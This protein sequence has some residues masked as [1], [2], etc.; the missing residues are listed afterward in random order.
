MIT[1]ERLK[2]LVKYDPTTGVFTATVRRGGYP[3]GT[4]LGSKGAKGYVYTVLD[5]VQYKTQYL[6]WVYM[7]GTSVPEGL[8]H[9]NGIRHDNRWENIAI[10]LEGS[11][12]T[13]RPF[14]ELV[15]GCYG[16]RWQRETRD[17]Y[18]YVGFGEGE[19]GIGVFK[20]KA[21]G[22]EARADE[23]KRMKIKGK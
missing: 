7:K 10:M 20:S 23:L 8:G 2:E 1:Q 11:S 21:A 19:R 18:V 5:G 3:L 4:A 14:R 13:T 9:I 12:V 17:W 22:V 6:A 15:S 16:V